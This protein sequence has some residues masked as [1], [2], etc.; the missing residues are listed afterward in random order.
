MVGNGV[1]DVYIK[2]GLISQRAEDW[3]L[4]VLC[5][6]AEF[7]FVLRKEFG[8]AGRWEMQNLSNHAGH[9]VL[10]A[11]NSQSSRLEKNQYLETGKKTQGTHV[12]QGWLLRW[13]R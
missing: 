3:I 9:A 5:V 10:S 12:L 13:T 4:K 8:V 1:W 2:T 7:V 6:T 11:L